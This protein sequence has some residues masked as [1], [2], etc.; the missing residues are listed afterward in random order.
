VLHLE[1]LGFA[2]GLLLCATVEARIDRLSVAVYSEEAVAW[3]VRLL[4]GGCH[5]LGRWLGG[6]C[7]LMLCATQPSKQWRPSKAAQQESEA[8]IKAVKPQHQPRI[9]PLTSDSKHNNIHCSAVKSTRTTPTT[10]P[11]PCASCATNLL[12]FEGS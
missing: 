8:I 1:A 3:L 12:S 4:G 11:E 10:A 5:L 7:R 6:G 9:D 2:R